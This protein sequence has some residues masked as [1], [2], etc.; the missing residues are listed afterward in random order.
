MRLGAVSQASIAGVVRQGRGHAS[1]ATA[2]FVDGDLPETMNVTGTSLVNVAFTADLA[3][4]TVLSALAGPARHVAPLVHDGLPGMRLPE[5]GT[6]TAF[7]WRRVEGESALTQ[8]EFARALSSLAGLKGAPASARAQ[9][10]W[11]R[12]RMRNLTAPTRNERL[13]L[14]AYRL[15]GYGERLTAPLLML[16]CLIVLMNQL[17]LLSSPISLSASGLWHWL[18]G[19]LDWA[20]TPLHLLRLTEPQELAGAFAQPWDTLARLVLAVPFA[21][22]LLILR[23]YVKEDDRAGQ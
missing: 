15:I 7:G 11:C 23:K 1:E 20:I 21:T 22:S 18:R 13:L 8:A 12:Y 2:L 9:L 6:V 10:A 5:G 17:A 14:S 19:L 3:G 16:G 4:I